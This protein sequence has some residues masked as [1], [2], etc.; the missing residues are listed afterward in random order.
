MNCPI[1][2]LLVIYESNSYLKFLITS[3][4]ICHYSSMFKCDKSVSFRHNIMITCKI[5]VDFKHSK[6]KMQIKKGGL[7]YTF[8]CY[9]YGIKDE[10]ICDPME[11]I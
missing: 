2:P 9:Q 6:I 5:L 10:E 8:A 7:E 1:Q 11:K 3:Q 4:V